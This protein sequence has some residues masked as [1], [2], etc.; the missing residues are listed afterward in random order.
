MKRIRS[1]ILPSTSIGISWYLLFL[2]GIR[3]A[4]LE[5]GE[6][7]MRPAGI[8][9]ILGIL[10]LMA[11]VAFAD[12]VTFDYDHSVNFLKYKTF[13]WVQEPQATVPFMQA[14]IVQSINRQLAVRGLRQ[15]SDGADL[16]LGAHL[17][18]EEKHT[19]QTYYSDSGGWGWGGSGWATT[20][21][22]TYEVGTLTV[23]MFDA[24]S[25]KLVWQGVA[26]DTL[27]HKPEKRTRE[28]DKEVEKMFR[29]FPPYT[30]LGSLWS[31]PVVRFRTPITGA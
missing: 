31:V 26:V 14:R 2:D 6:D 30:Y 1:V 21:V 11:I 20:T 27:S 18:T 15:V 29:G 25:K 16:A 10:F 28:F 12:K 3:L 4:P 19:W 13:M 7:N 8:A 9:V 5:H 17:A 23:D 22:Q 24:Q